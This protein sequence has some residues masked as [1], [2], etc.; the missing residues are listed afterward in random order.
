MMG[1]ADFFLSQKDKDVLGNGDTQPVEKQK[2]AI[3]FVD[4]EPNVLK[5]MVRIFRHEN[6]RI[7]LADSPLKAL[8]ILSEQNVHVVI[9]D[10]RMP[11]MTGADL[12]IKIKKQYPETIR[13]MLT[14]HAD[15]NAVMGAVNQGAVYKFITK[16]WNDDDLRLTV[17]LALEQ[18]DLRKENKILKEEQI[19]QKKSITKLK[20]YLDVNRSQLGTLLLKRNL[21]KEAD[22]EKVNSVQL[23][24]GKILPVILIEMGM[25]KEKQ[26]MDIIQSELKI[27][28][29][30]PAEFQVPGAL[31]SIIPKNLC[32]KNHMVPLKMN[33]RKLTVAM[34]DPSDFMKIDDIRFLTGIYLEPVIATQKEIMDKIIQVYGES[35]LLEDPAMEFD[36]SDPTESIEVIIEEDD[37]EID[38]KELLSAKD[39]PPAIRVV[40]SIISD[41]LR[42]GA[43]DVHIEPKIKYITVRYRIDG[44]LQ[45]KL[46]IPISMHPII[47]S[48]IKIMSELDI[49]ERRRP[50]NGR[51]T[52][53]TPTRIVDMRLA[54][55]PTINGEKIVLRIL[56]RNAPVKHL[57]E[58]GLSDHQ[59]ALLTK[60]IQKPQGCILA[61]GPTGSGKTST[62][63][64]IIYKNATIE[65]NFTT[66][67]DPVEYYMSMAEQVM[68]KEKIGLTFPIILKT[69]LRQDPDV[70]MLGEIRDF[71]TAEVTFHAALTGHTV[72]STLHT[73]SSLATITRLMDMGVKS[74]VLS[75]ALNGIIAQRLVRR[76]CPD[77]MIDD[78]MYKETIAALNMDEE[79]PDLRAKKGKGC[80]TCNFTGYSGRIG[81]YEIFLITDEIKYQ[82]QKSASE[83]E[84]ENAARQSGMITLY[85]AGM[86]KVKNG[87]TTCDE[88]LRV[89]GPQNVNIYNC[90]GCGNKIKKGN[91][92]CPYCGKMFYMKCDKCSCLLKPNW[93]ACPECGLRIKKRIN[94]SSDLTTGNQNG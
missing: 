80:N 36:L 16:P 1:I 68:V 66:I 85:E 94:L 58:L 17:S 93:N 88:I 69:I 31:T 50:Q 70:I 19:E 9:S 27:K 51:I 7:L 64:S 21:I 89:L 42:H 67:E 75:Y 4:D 87:L 29:V 23:K 47:V 5:A 54:T 37:E 43:S 8:D 2:Y 74:H 77:C 44:L 61:T 63:Y 91:R 39:Q 62:L 52:V 34:A 10:Y 46:H 90:E 82:I 83:A 72:L 48:R 40:N 18:Y 79:Y 24:T 86:E 26:I 11:K 65:K 81:I 76:I 38:L 3:L 73:N 22:L 28:R 78:P 56:D 71:E 59:L 92:F 14:G 33:N 53:K 60:L 15:V 49:A 84:L 57:S 13:I 45:D 35:N 12:L 25:I 20:K 6:Y 55:L 32:I 41:A 30:Y